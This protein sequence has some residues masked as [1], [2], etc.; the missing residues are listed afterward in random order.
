MLAYGVV[1][2][3][4]FFTPHFPDEAVTVAGLLR[5]G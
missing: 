3:G 5:T 2:M 1:L 4:G